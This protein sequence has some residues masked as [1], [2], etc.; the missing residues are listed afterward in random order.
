[1]NLL[2]DQALPAP[3]ARDVLLAEQDTT[4]TTT[5]GSSNTSNSRRLQ[6]QQS[7]NMAR[8]MLQQLQANQSLPY[9]NDPMWSQLWHLQAINATGAWGTSTG[10]KDLVVAIIDTGCD[11]N[12]PDLKDNLWTNPREIPNNGIDD[13]GNGA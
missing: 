2:E 12:H 1:M 4:T 13:D 5:I 3:P 6:Q 8:K 10:A 9:P 7:N 11:L